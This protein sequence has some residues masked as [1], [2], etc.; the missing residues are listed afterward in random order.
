[1]I[2]IQ[3]YLS[4]IAP[5][6]S[7][8]SFFAQRLPAASAGTYLEKGTLDAEGLLAAVRKVLSSPTGARTA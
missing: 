1:M 4:T 7:I 2:R 6:T 3:G 8:F 5:A